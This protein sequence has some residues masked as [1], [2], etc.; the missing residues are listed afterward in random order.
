LA[1]GLTAANTLLKSNYKMGDIR[2]KLF[3]YNG[4]QTLVTYHP[5]AL[6]RNPNWKKPVWEDMKLLR[7]LYDES[8]EKSKRSKMRIAVLFG[9]ISTE[10][11]VSISGG[12]ARCRSITQ[13]WL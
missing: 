10:R 4:I 6:L 3:D 9:G 2:G 1:L 5:A 12:R 7:K 8:I 11:N 13:P